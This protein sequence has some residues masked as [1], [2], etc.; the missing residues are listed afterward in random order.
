MKQRQYLI[1]AY[2]FFLSVLLQNCTKK[3]FL[4]D[5][6]GSLVGYVYTFDEFSK[7]LDDHS[8]VMIL[9]IGKSEVYRTFSDKNG[10]FEFEN[11]PA[12][13]YELHFEKYGFGTLKQFGVKHL[14][15]EPTILN[16][17]FSNYYERSAFFIFK[18]T[19]AEIA[20]L[21]FQ[22]DSIYCRCHFA[23]NTPDHINIQIYSSLQDNFDIDLV[24]PLYSNLWLR[25]SGDNYSGSSKTIY[26]SGTFPYNHGEKVFIRACIA[27][28]YS[29]SVVLNNRIVRGI[30]TYFD[31]ELNRT[32]YPGLGKASDQCSFIVPE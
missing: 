24:Q 8:R 25:K 26:L 14:G 30:N 6:K 23:S 15:G 5:L 17:T 21:E 22:E 13:T 9:A 19:T 32:V 18:I 16:A 31:Y 11:L 20:Y 27:P 10:R 4:P 28:E 1:I 2:A 29:K 3:E 7:L 12:G